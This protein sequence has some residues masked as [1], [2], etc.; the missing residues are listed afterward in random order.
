MKIAMNAMNMRAGGGVNVVKNILASINGDDLLH[1][2]LFTV[3]VPKGLGYDNFRSA[4]IEIVEVPGYLTNPY[5]R[6]FLDTFWFNRMFSKIKSDVVFSL[7]NIALKTSV[8]QAVVFQNSY[9][10][11]GQEREISDRMNLRQKLD[12]FLT[13]LIFRLRLPYVKLLLPQ[14]ETISIQLKTIFQDYPFRIQVIPCGFETMGKPVGKSHFQK[15]DG[16]RYLICPSGYYPHKNLE[17]LLQVA[18]LL[19]QKQLDLIIVLTLEP[20]LKGKGG[21][22]LR[23]IPRLSLQDHIINIGRVPREEL[24]SMYSAS[25]ALIL[26]TLLE[27]YSLAYGEAMYHGLPVFTSDRPFAREVCGESAYYFDPLDAENIVETLMTYFSDPVVPFGDKGSVELKGTQRY[28]WQTITR[29]YIKRL[30]DLV[31]S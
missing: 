2:H 25:D 17:V 23:S 28:S 10:S 30:E 18:S 7:G 9:L 31:A 3:F 11:I 16:K 4:W 15:K 6:Y 19:K 1:E 8:P 5:S 14:T 27:S 21:A 24:A 13:R 12:L 29:M 22:L 26:P 20:G